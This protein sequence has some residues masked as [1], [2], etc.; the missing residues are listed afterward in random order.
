MLW[1]RGDDN[2]R[3]HDGD[4]RGNDGYNSDIETNIINKVIDEN[5]VSNDIYSDSGY[6]DYINNANGDGDI[7]KIGISS[8]QFQEQLDLK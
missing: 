3:S 8:L 5:N 7:N 4:G 6:H 2:D 1:S